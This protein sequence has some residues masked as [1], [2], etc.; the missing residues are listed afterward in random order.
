MAIVFETK[1]LIDV[2]A[3]TTMGLSAK[4]NTSSPIGYFGTGL[5]YSIAV[6][7]RLGCTP[8]VHIGLDTYRFE[9]R[10]AEFR[11]VAYDQLRMRQVKAG[12]KRARYHELP[13]TTEYGRNWEAWQVF[14][15]LESNTRDEGGTTYEAGVAN[16]KP[17]ADMTQIVVDLEAFDLAYANRDEI[18]LP[19]AQRTGTGVQVVKGNSEFIYWRGLRVYKPS[20]PT[21]FTYNF[22]VMLRLTEDRT[23]AAEYYANS[24]LAEHVIKSEDES[25]IESIVTCGDGFWESGLD[26]PAYMSP[27]RAF[28]NVMLRHPKH[29]NYG[30]S[31]YYESYR[32]KR[33]TRI[34]TDVWE[35][36]P[37]PWKLDGEIVVDAND[38]AVFQMPSSYDEDNNWDNVADAVLKCIHSKTAWDTE[39]VPVAPKAPAAI[40]S[41]DVLSGEVAQEDIEDD[42]E[43]GLGDGLPVRPPLS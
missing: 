8:V 41:N 43:R 38:K 33:P 42:Y 22:L 39:P 34:V 35:L 6:L 36:H 19:Q 9:K 10:P 12:W 37:L 5:K 27:S 15:E 3:F 4:P 21:R 30:V 7:V 23:L 40:F 14:R 20:K 2:R 13:Y 11:G 25:F 31:H 26:Y 1:G 28:H 16:V 32:P 24:A 18:F 17:T 29:V